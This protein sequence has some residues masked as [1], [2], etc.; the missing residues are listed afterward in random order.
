MTSWIVF[1]SLLVSFSAARTCGSNLR[2]PRGIITSPNYPVQ[3][4]NNAHCVW[5][6]TAMDS[7]KVSYFSGLICFNRRLNWKKNKAA[8]NLKLLKQCNPYM[9]L[10]NCLFITAAM[11]TFT[12]DITSLSFHCWKTQMHWLHWSCCSTNVQFISLNSHVLPYSHYKIQQ[13]LFK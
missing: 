4:E 11:F 6:I 1:P 12:H 10:R 13:L 9:L 7:G 8:Y 3:Y 2:G 5:V